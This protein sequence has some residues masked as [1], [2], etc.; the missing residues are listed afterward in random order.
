MDYLN[1]GQCKGSCGDNNQFKFGNLHFDSPAEPTYPP[2]YPATSDFDWE[3][4]PWDTHMCADYG[5]DEC[6]YA[7]R[8]SSC[9]MS[10]PTGDPKKFD[11]KDAKCR[12]HDP[13]PYPYN[14]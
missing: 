14:P 10:Y 4:A 8:C 3:E 1:H 11:S 12:C 2:S 6:K 7:W 9:R 13:T 5:V